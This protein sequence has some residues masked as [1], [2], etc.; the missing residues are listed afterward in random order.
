VNELAQPFEFS[1]QA[2]SKHLKV[3]ERAGLIGRGQN[4]R[5]QPCRREAARLDTAV[6]RIDHY[7][8]PGAGRSLHGRV[9]A[10]HPL[11]G[12]D[13]RER[14][15]I[16]N[17]TIDPRPGQ[18]CETIMMNDADGA[19]H[20]SRGIYVEVVEPEKLV[21]TEPEAEGA[22]TASHHVHRPRRWHDRGLHAPDERS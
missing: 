7:R 15:P 16:E 19:E 14:G 4:A 12:S 18:V 10:P 13:R 22:M 3:L 11:L 20:A 8:P 5:F 6:D 1:L 21:W 9:G 2:I 17:L